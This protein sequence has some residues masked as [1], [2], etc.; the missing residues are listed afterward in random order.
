MS[1]AEHRVHST[2]EGE[3]VLAAGAEFGRHD[4]LPDFLQAVL[5]GVRNLRDVTHGLRPS[6]LERVLGVF[7]M[8]FAVLG[9]P[10]VALSLPGHVLQDPGVLAEDTDLG[11][12]EQAHKGD[13]DVG[14]EGVL[15][16]EHREL[17]QLHVRPVD[18][19][20]H[21][22]HHERA[23]PGDVVARRSD[24]HPPPTRLLLCVEGVIHGQ[25]C[26]RHLVPRDPQGLGTPVGSDHRDQ[27]DHDER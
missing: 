3:E 12:D 16:G 9:P 14:E 17:L 20:L 22:P 1:C 7:R 10:T 25:H 19:H 21:L 5:H 2:V 24:L 27:G 11:R 15:R 8:A 4:L 26:S 23:Q 13:G 6:L 18:R